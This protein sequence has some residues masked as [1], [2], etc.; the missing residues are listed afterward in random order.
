MIIT[1]TP[2]RL[3]FFG[4][5]TDYRPWFEK[6]G[7]LI[8]STTFSRFCYI[9]LRR[10]PP[11]FE[12]KTRAVYSKQELVDSNFEIVHPAIKACFKHLSIE[13]GLEIHHDGDLPAWSG[14]GSSSSFTVGF[15]LALHALKNQM[16]SPKKLADEAIHVEQN[17]TNEHVGIQDQIIAAHGGSNI[18]GINPGE[19]YTVSPL[20]LSK[21]YKKHLEK[22]IM[23]G[24]SGV[25]RLSSDN[26][27]KVIKQIEEGKIDPQMREIQSIAFE[28]LNRLS[29]SAEIE[30]IG[31]LID[32]SWKIKKSLSPTVTCDFFEN[33]Y[34]EAIKA[35][36]FGGRLLGAG[37]GGFFMLLAPPEK[38]DEIK[39]KLSA[40]KVWVPFN[41]ELSGAQVILHTED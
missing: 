4:G 25:K 38:H 20:M 39:D 17:V 8:V 37:G 6:N 34:G 26:A 15:L 35:G 19:D 2:Y 33:I 16:I 40:V 13:D 18:I 30:S 7:G 27:G 21:D 5:G 29:E 32:A 28:G 11:F 24:F 36:A 14:V 31:K 3:S 41:F 23:L 12:H 9:S 10:L 1:K 22:H